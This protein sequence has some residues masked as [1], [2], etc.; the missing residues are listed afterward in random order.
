MPTSGEPDFADG[1][2]CR[3]AERVQLDG[4]VT[5]DKLGLSRSAVPKLTIAEAIA[6]LTA[7]GR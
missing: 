1:L 6:L 3:A 5:R 7:E 2:V 4:I